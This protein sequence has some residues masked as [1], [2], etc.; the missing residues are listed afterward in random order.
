MTGKGYKWVNQILVSNLCPADVWQSFLSQA[1]PFVGYGLHPL[2]SSCTVMDKAFNDW[3]YKCF[4]ALGVNRNI[5]K[6]KKTPPTEY[7]GLGLPNMSLEKLTM[8]LQYLQKHWGSTTKYYTALRYT[9][10]LIQSEIELSGNFLLRN[11]KQFGCLATHSWFK[12][13]WEYLDLFN[14]QLQLCDVNI[15]QVWEH[16]RV[17]MKEVIRILLCSEW[18]SFNCAHKYFRVYFMSQLVLRDG[19]TVSPDKVM[20]SQQLSPNTKFSHETPTNSDFTLWKTT[21]TILTSP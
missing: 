15:P 1:L 13:L 10:E 7:Q 11:Y 14:D 4:P 8:F 21:I 17:L 12:V 6:E 3:Y 18:V 16:D 2:M 20:W 9:Y 5:T 19:S